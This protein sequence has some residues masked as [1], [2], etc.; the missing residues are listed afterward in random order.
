M[1]EQTNIVKRL[2]GNNVFLLLF[3]V[4]F[5]IL[6]AIYGSYSLAK[7]D[8]ESPY[9]YSSNFI[10]RKFYCKPL[11]INCKPRKRFKMI[12]KQSLKFA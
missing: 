6:M 5:I 11:K 4:A 9:I 12:F 2:I 8:E 7:T 10:L 3:H 1:T